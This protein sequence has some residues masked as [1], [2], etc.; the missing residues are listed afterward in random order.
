MAEPRPN[1]VCF[2]T[3]QQR[4]DHLG[5]MG[6]PDIRTPNID[7]LA[8]EGVVFTESFVANVVCMPNRA[9]MF[10]GRYPKAHGVRENGI[11]LQPTDDA[12][13]DVLRRAGYRTAAFG[14]LHLRPF[15]GE[16]A[17][18]LKPHELVESREFWADGGELPLPYFGLEHVYFVGGHVYYVFGQYKRD[19]D[20]E[21]PGA[22]AMYAKDHALKPPTGAPES[23]STPIPPELHYN[24]T[25]ADKAIEYIK[26]HD[27]GRPFFIW[28]SFPDPH[29]PFV[30]PQP[31]CDQ[32]DPRAITFSPIR[33]DGEIDD[34]PPHFRACYEGRQSTA[35][36]DWDM[37]RVTDE[38][39]R[40]M[41][42]HT[43]G[44]ISMVDDNVGRVVSALEERGLLDDTVIVFL[45]DHADMMGDH[46]LGKKGPFLFRS[47]T[48]IP[49][50]WRLP[51]RFGARRESDALVSSVDLMPTLLDLAGVP[52]PDGVQGV[53]YRQV[54]TGE[55]EAIRDWAYIEYDESYINDRLRQI[56]SKGW[57][58]TY[59][60]NSG[61][62]MLFDLRSDPRELHNVW[63]DPKHRDVK[64]DLLVELLRQTAQADDWLPLK[65]SHA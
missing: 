51:K 57:A 35:G 45:S 8:R 48:R 63:N 37:R 23:W 14:K 11:P 2:V 49:T 28:C 54:L 33:R 27:A 24:T 38:H 12:L 59:H 39:L 44:M 6:N 1:I 58:I 43:Y 55:K 25:I 22:H 20:R 31:Y 26:A 17:Q 62:G 40:E 46:W 18:G 5:C 47:L 3:D 61:D 41:I 16:R 21:H 9:S 52:A 10:T 19:L 15:G 65:K 29:H 64:R 50:V 13:P 34:L 56:R 4:A 32:Y 60:V 7:R 36:L 53:S 30:A 42:A